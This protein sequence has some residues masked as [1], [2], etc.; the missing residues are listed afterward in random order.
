VAPD[1]TYTRNY[2]ALTHLPA[3]TYVA[4]QSTSS[5]NTLNIYTKH[6]FTCPFRIF[7]EWHIST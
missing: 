1:T 3:T 7:I 5:L 4:I 2:T 6:T